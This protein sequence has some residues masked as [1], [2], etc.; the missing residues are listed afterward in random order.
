MKKILTLMLAVI[1]ILASSVILVGGTGKE[2]DKTEVSYY[3]G[4]A[5]TSW[6]NKNDVKKEYHI[7]SAD[8]L[9]GFA[10]IVR[11]GQKFAG[12]TFYLDCD[13]V[14]NDGEFTM[15]ENGKPLY[16]GSPVSDQNKPK[17]F[18][19]IGQYIQ[20]NAENDPGVS[21]N[22]FFGNFDGQGHVISGLY[23]YEPEQSS[24]GFFTVFAGEYIKDLS[25]V[26]SY[27]GTFARSATFAGFVYTVKEKGTV[28]NAGTLISGLY[29]D[30]MVV[31]F[32]KTDGQNGRL[33]GIIGLMLPI[34]YNGAKARTNGCT[35]VIENCW[36]AGDIQH[37]KGTRYTGGILGVM[38][39]SNV[40]N[41]VKLEINNCLMTGAFYM[42]LDPTEALRV[43]GIIGNIWRGTATLNNCVSAISDTNVLENN[44]FNATNDGKCVFLGCHESEPSHII[45]NNCYYKPMGRF[46]HHPA[47]VHNGGPQTTDT[48]KP[49]KFDD[50]KA[51][52]NAFANV[53]VFDFSGD[54]LALKLRT[55]IDA[56]TSLPETEP[57]TEPLTEPTTEPATEPLT[58]P[59]TEPI[60]E[61]STE[62][63]DV[64]DDRVFP[65]DTVVT[66]PQKSSCGGISLFASLLA[67]IALTGTAIVINRK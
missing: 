33:G 8:M 46:D 20:N 35:Q 37:I 36:F 23:V 32:N 63:E 45:Y 31:A 17:S 9:A 39:G 11:G 15:D 38:A 60:T 4:K 44:Y 5:D 14:W 67:L 66:E 6:Y 13:I 19:P 41:K 52:V 40:S 47:N 1:M 24:V 55:G 48:G 53:S 7:T 56:D 30:A 43:G 49:T 21:G 16:N 59:I 42:G 12:T 26:N 58:E 57:T 54:E 2:A 27:F 18:L 65:T 10:T 50:F 62:P 22:Y 34:N 29:S 61:P 25:I 64:T 28:S 51:L 3:S